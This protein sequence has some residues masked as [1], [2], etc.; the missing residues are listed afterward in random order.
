MGRPP[1]GKVAMTGAERVRRYRLKQRI[2]QHAEQAA[3]R[4][5]PTNAEMDVLIQAALIKEKL[6]WL[7]EHPGKTRRDFNKAMRNGE[8]VERR[9][10]KA[11]AEIAA[12]NAAWLRDYPS[13]PLPE[14]LC[15][16]TDDEYAE[17]E[18]WSTRRAKAKRSSR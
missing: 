12:E 16:L 2:K 13:R 10:A 11:K 17:Y 18:A 4:P 7:R 6:Q 5:T 14:H 1:L 3:T 9:K 8:I 15:G